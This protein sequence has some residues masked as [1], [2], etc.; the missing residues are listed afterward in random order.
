MPSRINT[1]TF[2]GIV[3]D[4][5]VNT[6]A[7]NPGGI[8]T[9][10]YSIKIPA[11][12]FNVGD[13]FTVHSLLIRNSASGNIDL[14][15]Y[16]NDSDDVTNSPIL[17]SSSVGAVSH[18]YRPLIRTFAV[19]SDTETVHMRP[20]PYYD[21]P[22]DWGQND[23]SDLTSNGGVS[24]VTSSNLNWNI[25]SWIILASS[26]NQPVTGYFMSVFQ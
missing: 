14:R 16:W 11:N 2:P 13:V 4:T 15:I 17:I 1:F 8:L 6:T 9:K 22:D 7:V 19:V 25:D 5:T 3:R 26:N 21:Y 12:T 10:L 20:T 18:L 23:V 24:P